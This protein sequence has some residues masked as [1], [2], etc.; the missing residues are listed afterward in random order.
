ML[1]VMGKNKC[2]TSRFRDEETEANEDGAMMGFVN[3]LCG[4]ML[5]QFGK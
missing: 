2:Y 1:M 5:A 4:E 3:Y